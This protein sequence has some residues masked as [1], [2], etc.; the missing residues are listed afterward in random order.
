MAC[1]LT[2]LCTQYAAWYVSLQ[3]TCQ[4]IT[5]FTQLSISC[6]HIVF[7]CGINLF[8]TALLL[9]CKH[10]ALL[11]TTLSAHIPLYTNSPDGVGP[12][13]TL[14]PFYAALQMLSAR[15]QPFLHSTL[16]G[17]SPAHSPFY[18][19]LQTAARREFESEFPHAVQQTCQRELGEP[20]RD[21][22]PRII[23]YHSAQHTHWHSPRQLVW[24]V[25]LIVGTV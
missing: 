2:T 5:P 12:F 22:R 10:L 14:S 18:I 23:S 11:Y 4:H 3:F 13:Y 20:E 25:L 9:G 6:L 17:A 7:L 24:Y 19:E 16:D 1:Q 8:Y 21:Q 15:T